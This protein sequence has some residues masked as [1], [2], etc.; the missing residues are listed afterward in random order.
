MKI[1]KIHLDEKSESVQLEESE[2]D[3]EEKDGAFKEFA[4]RMSE[5]FVSLL[6]Q[7]IV[8]RES[9]NYDKNLLTKEIGV[10]D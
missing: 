1:Y 8:A 7:R 4:E 5:P 10:V 2:S 6:K 9:K 3:D